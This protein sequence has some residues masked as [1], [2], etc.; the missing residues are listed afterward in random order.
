[1]TSSVS[2]GVEIV[3]PSGS[4]ARLAAA[5]T[6]IATTSKTSAVRLSAVVASIRWRF[7][8]LCNC[9]LPDSGSIPT[10]RY[11]LER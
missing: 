11:P 8:R 3:R 5:D 4:V 1:M 9:P 7:V 10:T 2:V 6:G